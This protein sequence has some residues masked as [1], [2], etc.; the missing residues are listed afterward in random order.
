MT[1]ADAL[2]RAAAELALFVGPGFLLLGLNDVAVDWRQRP[3][4]TA[5]PASG[6]AL[7][8]GANF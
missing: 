5:E 6:P 1:A 4:G 8:V 7:T 2:V 3:A